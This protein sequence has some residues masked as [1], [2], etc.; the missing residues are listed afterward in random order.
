MPTIKTDTDTESPALPSDP[1]AAAAAEHKRLLPLSIAAL[2]IVFGDIGTSP[3]YAFRECFLSPFHPIEPTT[4][5]VLG[6]LSLIFWSLIIVISVKYLIFVMRADNRGEGGILALLALLQPQRA[7]PGLGR[8]ALILLAIFGAALLYGDSM[9]TPAISVLSAIEGLK[10]AAPAS[11]EFVIPL[12]IAVL[13]LLFIFQRHGTAKIG[14]AFGPIMI[15]WFAS[16]AA[17]GVNSIIDRPE[18]LNAVAPG[19]GIHFFFDNGWI[20]FLVLGSVFLSVTGGEALY[21]D[22]GHFGRLPI[23]LV[24][25]VLVLPALLLNY[26]GQGALLLRN[27]A[28]TT[29]PFYHLAPYWAL[30]P[31]LVLAT[32]ATVIA[33]QAVI[34]GAFSLTRQAVQLGECPR[35][36]IEQTSS[37]EIGQIYVPSINWLLMI[38]TIALVLSFRSSGNLAAAYGIAVSGTMLITSILA[39]V[40]ARERGGWSRLAAGLLVILFLAADVSFFVANS[41]KIEEGGWF[42]L[43]VAA[44]LLIIMTTWNKGQR[45]LNQRLRLVDQ[46]LGQ[47]LKLLMAHPPARVKGTAIFM[48]EQRTSTPPMFLHHLKH[49]QVLHEQVVFCTVLTRRVPR[50]SE[51]ERIRVR[52]LGNGLVPGEYLLRLYGRSRHT[53]G[54]GAVQTLWTGAGAAGLHLLHRPVD[55]DRQFQKGRHGDLDQEIIRSDATQFLADDRFL[56]H[57]TGLGDRNRHPGTVLGRRRTQRPADCARGITHDRPKRQRRRQPHSEFAHRGRRHRR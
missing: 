21:A 24:W 57:P 20:G 56:P 30:Q 46:P 50:M 23:R 40:V 7:T 10:V 1:A 26:F 28:E 44:I 6:V 51:A 48:T 42:P 25:F 3:L 41:L 52:K 2:G 32:L 19:Y 39:Y 47:F 33:S 22:M 43:L 55:V 36:R 9:I 53:G 31:L 37:T 29:E 18:V 13:L 49:N 4:H 16:L 45:I 38:A 11:E 15:I 27:P 35:L 54:A 17:L 8:K 12:T 5:N 34:S 14:A